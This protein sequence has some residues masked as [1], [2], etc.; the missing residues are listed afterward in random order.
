MEG[1]ARRLPELVRLE[2]GK[3]LMGSA[4]PDIW[5]NDGEGPVRETSLRPFRIGVCAVTNREFGEFIA[6]TGYATEAERFGWS[7]VF[8]LHVPKHLRHSSSVAGLEWWIGVEGARWNQPFGPGS[9]LAKSQSHPVVHVTWNDAIAYAAW[10]GLRLPTEAEWEFA[11]RGGLVQNRFPW[12]NELTPGGRHMCNIWQGE[13]PLR[14]SAADGY[15]GTA[16]A[17]AFA[18]NGYGL[19]NVAGNVWEWCA[20]WHHPHY[21][22]LGHRDNPRG[23]ERGDRKVTR[24]GSFLCHESYCNRYRVSARTGNTPDTSSGNTGFRVAGDLPERTGDS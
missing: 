20:D 24:G 23:P 14:D 8:H 16:P 12:G 7:Y 11:A 9:D 18:P 5:V 6:A 4:D 21:A 22:L 3:F 1:S 15:A 17:K 10:A 13:F 2:G 19:Y